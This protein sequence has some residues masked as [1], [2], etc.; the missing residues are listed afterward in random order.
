MSTSRTS[1]YW[2]QGSQGEK[3]RRAL[4]F[5]GD[6]SESFQWHAAFP[7]VW[8]YTVHGTL[9]TLEDLQNISKTCLKIQKKYYEH[10]F[11]LIPNDILKKLTRILT[12]LKG[13]KVHSHSHSE[14]KAIAQN[15]RLGYTDEYHSGV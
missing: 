10:C 1:S 4:N 14:E 12:P 2:L 7:I 13:H 8:H 11:C 9:R 3:F 5:I 15:V 6:S